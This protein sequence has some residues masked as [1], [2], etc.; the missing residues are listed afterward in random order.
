[1]KFTC[2]RDLIN[3]EIS[4]A[5]EIISS[6]NVMS[7]LSNVL[8]EAAD[9]RL[10]IRA[11]DLKVG[12]ETQIPVQVAAP[13]TA[14]VYCDKLVGILRSLPGGEVEF[15]LDDS[16]M[17]FIRP[18][19]KKINF[20]LKSIASDKYPEIQAVSEGSYF[21]VSQA[22]L[23]DMISNTIFAVSDDETRYFMN[24]VYLEKSGEKLN[25]VASDG[26]RLS[27]ISKAIDPAVSDISGVI[28]PPKILTLI[29]KL[30]P[31]E[32]N[33]ALCVTDKNIFMRFG[34]RRVSSNLIDGQFP[35]YARVIPESQDYQIVVDRVQLEDALKRVSLLVEQKARRVFLGLSENTLVVS[36]EESEIGMA[37]EEIPCEYVGP[38]VTVALNYAYLLEPL[39]EIDSEQVSLRYTDINKAITLTSI[40]EKDYLHIIMPMQAK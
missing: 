4:I 35:N 11:T 6:R 1:M 22:D 15:E 39:R 37:R 9:D 38:D 36:S 12:F 32:G 34:E 17:L 21:E 7:I 20:K 27:F 3:K 24:G 30:L 26:R 5:Q 29:R 8:L 10:I 28:I 33:L 18:L 16:S 19:V 14:T 2:D 23:T 40:P 31:G 25:M 13:G